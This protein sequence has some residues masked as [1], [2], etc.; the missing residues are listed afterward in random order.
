MP[1]IAC[2]I[3]ALIRKDCA[4]T[5]RDNKALIRKDC[6]KTGRDN[7]A[8]IRKDCAKTGRDNTELIRKDCAKIILIKRLLK[9]RSPALVVLLPFVDSFSLS[10]FSYL[11][12]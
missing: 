12:N 11:N 7:T 4:K 2:G 9:S 6:A 8:L 5:G 3:T 10:V 1:K